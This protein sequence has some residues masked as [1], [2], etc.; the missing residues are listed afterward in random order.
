MQNRDNDSQ[1]AWGAVTED[2]RTGGLNNRHLLLLFVETGSPGSR[3][4]RVQFLVETL[5]GLQMATLSSP[6]LSSALL[7]LLGMLS[8]SGQGPTLPYD[9][10][11]S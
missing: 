4:S 2:H 1:C 11:L 10:T 3:S 8:L 9:P 7:S 5:S 6:S